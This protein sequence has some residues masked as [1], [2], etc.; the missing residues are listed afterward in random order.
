MQWC[1]GGSVAVVEQP[2]KGAGL[3]IQQ[4]PLYL[5]QSVSAFEESEVELA[6]WQGS[7]DIAATVRANCYIVIPADREHIPAGEWV[8]VMRSSY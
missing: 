6:A 4:A 8:A 3:A 2:P 7:G 1:A 5:E